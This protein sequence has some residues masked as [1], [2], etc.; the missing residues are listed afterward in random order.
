[1]K[2]SIY[3]CGYVGL[4]TGVCQAKLGHSILCFDID[5][6][7]ID[8]LNKGIPTISE[9]NFYALFKEVTESKKIQFSSSIEE[10]IEF[11][12]I[13]L[14]SVGTPPN[15]DGSTNLSYIESIAENLGQLISRP[16]LFIIKSTIPVGTT[17]HIENIINQNIKKRGLSIPLNIAF[18][19]EFFIEGM[20]VST[21][22]KA[23]RIII[24]AK[25]ETS[26]EQVA[27]LYDP[28]VS[29][30][31]IPLV[32]M[33]IRSAELCKYAANAFLGTKISFINELS[34]IAKKTGADIHEIREGLS[35]DKRIG[36]SMA[37]PGCGFG[38]S[39]LPKDI[40]S[41][42]F[43]AEKNEC[44]AHILHAVLK[45]NEGQFKIFFDKI[46]QFFGNNLQGRIIALWGL[47]FKPNTDDIRNSV[48]CKLIDV[49]LSKGAIVQGYDPIAKKNFIKKYASEI[50]EKKI[51]L[52]DNKDLALKNADALVIPT[53]WDEFYKINY[54]ILKEN[55][56]SPVVFDGRFIYDSKT[57]K[58]NG[59]IYIGL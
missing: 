41:L 8:L 47:S 7:K 54:S 36:S 50:A 3:G 38:G 12:D 33:S 34:N 17:D 24:G 44:N 1:M 56:K 18:V 58:E 26:F 23:E 52:F 37:F 10:A 42:I 21:F 6:E 29:Q 57:M 9:N 30:D 4:I 25:D 46:S 45:V 59:I 49:F 35:L 32:K 16:S 15:E 2:I 5:K 43:I 22:M 53:E 51:T 31:K 19:P 55:M 40:S 48:S 20:A 27:K 28:L 13:H 14:I 11:S 39:C